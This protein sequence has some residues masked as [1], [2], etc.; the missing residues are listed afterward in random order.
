MAIGK[1]LILISLKFVSLTAFF[2]ESGITFSSGG[3]WEKAAVSP[4]L[5]IRPKIKVLLKFLDSIFPSLS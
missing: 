5:I 3:V 4:Q 2:I 1:D